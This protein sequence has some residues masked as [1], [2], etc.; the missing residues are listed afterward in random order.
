MTRFWRIY[1]PKHAKNSLI[2]LVS[3]PQNGAKLAFA[4]L[5][6]HTSTHGAPKCKRSIALIWATQARGRWVGC[7]TNWGEFGGSQTFPDL[8]IFWHLGGF[9]PKFTMLLPFSRAPFSKSTQSSLSCFGIRI[10]FWHYWARRSRHANFQV[11]SFS[12]AR[13]RP[14]NVPACH[15]MWSPTEP[16]NTMGGVREVIGFAEEW[17]HSTDTN[18]K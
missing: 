6:A 7:F 18:E 12:P 9:L 15:H 2:K 1:L 17:W 4:T 8:A 3:G 10:R 13:T 14:G 11:K 16:C 5:C